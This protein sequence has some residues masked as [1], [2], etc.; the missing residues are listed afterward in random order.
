MQ[1]HS[2]DFE[3]KQLFDDHHQ[4]VHVDS[5]SSRKH[6]LESPGNFAS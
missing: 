5:G 3:V 6:G 1:V 2:F 4:T